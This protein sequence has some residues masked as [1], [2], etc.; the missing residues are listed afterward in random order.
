MPDKLMGNTRSSYPAHYSM[1]SDED[2]IHA[3]RKFRLLEVL[4]R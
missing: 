4:L 2:Y 1:P 3:F